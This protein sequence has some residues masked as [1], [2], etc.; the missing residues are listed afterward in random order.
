[1]LHAI[2]GEV[3]DR[4]GRPPM[5][6]HVLA[7]I[8][9]RVERYRAKWIVSGWHSPAW[10]G[11]QRQRGAKGGKAKAGRPYL[12]GRKQR[13]FLAEMTDRELAKLMGVT[14]RT[15]RNWKRSGK[16]AEKISDL[17]NTVNAPFNRTILSESCPPEAGDNDTA[18]TTAAG[19]GNPPESGQDPDLR[20]S[21]GTAGKI[22]GA[23]TPSGAS[24][25]G[26]DRG[27]NGLDPD[28]TDWSDPRTREFWKRRH[29]G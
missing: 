7:D 29:G 22:S 9:Q 8:A 1:M 21:G 18:K 19:G 23:D 28:L 25:G 10:I 16:L 11:R 13:S 24:S 14:D 17:A 2:N 5:P 6:D 4:H 15:I 12:K 3:A 26:A 27:G 20:A